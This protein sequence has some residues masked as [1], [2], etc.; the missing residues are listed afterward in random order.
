MQ[1]IDCKEENS[2]LSRIFAAALASRRRTFSA[3]KRTKPGQLKELHRV[4]CTSID[5]ARTARAMAHG[6]ALACHTISIMNQPRRGTPAGAVRYTVPTRRTEQF[7][8][9]KKCSTNS[10]N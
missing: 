2:E 6:I 8:R 3:P 7:S 4:H 1:A 5:L 9:R 10:C